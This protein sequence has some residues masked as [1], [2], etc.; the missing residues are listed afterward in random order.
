MVPQWPED[1]FIHVPEHAFE[2]ILVR[3]MPWWWLSS[4]VCKPRL[5][6]ETCAR[7]LRYYAWCHA[8]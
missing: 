4:T 3:A 8:T 6:S 7:C 5:P 2:V 1:G